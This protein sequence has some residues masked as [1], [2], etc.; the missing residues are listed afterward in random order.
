MPLVGLGMEATTT[1]AKAVTRVR[2]FQ[3]SATICDPLLLAPGLVLYQKLLGAS[4]RDSS[5]IPHQSNV[6]GFERERCIV[7]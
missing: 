5:N 3:P 1:N 4:T 2:L 6:L 7:Q